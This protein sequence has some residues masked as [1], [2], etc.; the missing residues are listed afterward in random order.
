MLA[1]AEEAVPR[2]VEV[3]ILRYAAQR[4]G[5]RFVVA[6]SRHAWGRAALPGVHVLEADVFPA[7]VRGLA[8]TRRG[9]QDS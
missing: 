7:R 9:G 8:S 1:L 3:E 2:R 6:C 4:T 5:Y